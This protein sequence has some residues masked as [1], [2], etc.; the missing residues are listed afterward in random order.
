MYVRDD[1]TDLWSVINETRGKSKCPMLS[2]DS[3]LKRQ[4][5][6]ALAAH[7]SN[8]SP[9][10][11]GAGNSR[12]SDVVTPARLSIVVNKQTV[13][14]RR[15]VLHWWWLEV[16]QGTTEGLCRPARPLATKNEW[17]C[18][19]YNYPPA[20]ISFQR[21]F[22]INRLLK[23][24]SWIIQQKLTVTCPAHINLTKRQLDSTQRFLLL[25]FFYFFIF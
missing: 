7:S 23:S 18:C 24:P 1:T 9:Q 4:S 21:P 11:T 10:T 17:T 12:L 13:G 25:Y 15:T 5:V 19:H 16:Q 8:I 14:R 20:S 2:L 3:T 6:V 22:K